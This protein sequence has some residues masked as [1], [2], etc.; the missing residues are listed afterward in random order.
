[1]DSL[2]RKMIQ[3]L[4]HRQLASQRAHLS[5]HQHQSAAAV[6]IELGKFGALY[7]SSARTSGEWR[8]HCLRHA[9]NGWTGAVH[10]ALDQGELG[11]LRALSGINRL[12]TRRALGWIPKRLSEAY[13]DIA[14]EYDKRKQAPSE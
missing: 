10:N 2:Q 6:K 7:R 13:A 4:M 9:K 12:G 14:K 8:L 3:I 5:D 1:M 11:I